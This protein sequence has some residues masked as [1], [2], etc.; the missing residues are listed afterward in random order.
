[1]IAC[2]NCNA[3]CCRYAA[4]EL[5][6]P[7]NKADWD[8]IKWLLMHENVRVYKDNEGEW[9]AELVTNC[10]NLMPDNKCRIYASRPELCKN[11]EVDC[12]VMNGDGEVEEIL[13]ISPEDVDKYLEEKGLKDKLK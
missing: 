5:D 4:I 3:K 1:M 12:C 9:V 8:E 2:E 7:K 13:F 6:M 10:K 11:H